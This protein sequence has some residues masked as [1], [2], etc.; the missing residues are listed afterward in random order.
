MCIVIAKHFKDLGWV[1]VKNLDRSYKPEMSIKKSF[2]RD[3]ERLLLWDEGTHWTEGV[4][5]YGIAIISGAAGSRK[6]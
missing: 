1:G 3:I 5:E 4:N 2:R 6:I